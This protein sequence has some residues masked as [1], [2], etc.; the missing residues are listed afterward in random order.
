[1][2]AGSVLL[3]T[4]SYIAVCIAIAIVHAS[5]VCMHGI[6]LSAHICMAIC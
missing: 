4:Y 5:I 3:V 6:M 1:M 2:C